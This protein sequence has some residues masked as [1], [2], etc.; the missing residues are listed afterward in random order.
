MGRDDGDLVAKSCLT[1]ATPCTVDY[2]APPSMGF[3]R[4]YWSGLSFPSPGDLPDPGIEPGSPASQVDFCIADGFFTDWAMWLSRVER[5][6]LFIVLP[7]VTTINT[8]L[9]MFL[10]TQSLWNLKLNGQC[11]L[12]PFFSFHFILVVLGLRKFLR[13][14]RNSAELIINFKWLSVLHHDL[15]MYL[16]IK[17]LPKGPHTSMPAF[18]T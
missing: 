16:F 17:Y 3:S 14:A 6:V 8:Q 4:Q 12:P 11:L 9:A 10:F 13:K 7:E 5:R 1:L 18:H 15:L 2:Q